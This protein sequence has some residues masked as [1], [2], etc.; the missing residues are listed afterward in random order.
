MKTVLIH[1]CI[2]CLSLF[3][4]LGIPFL[5][6][7]A[8]HNLIHGKADATSSASVVLKQP[9]GQYI[10]LINKA[11]HTN[12]ENLDTWTRFFDGKEIDY[13]FEDIVCYVCQGDGLGLSM[14]QSYQSR[15]P[16][17]QMRIKI[18]DPT[19]LFSKADHGIFDIVVMSKEMA[20]AFHAET[21]S[22]QDGV[23][24]ITVKGEAS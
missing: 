24:T 2:V 13:L 6:T 12:A 11:R 4:I 22:Q 15:L 19:L 10:V 20:D 16:A 18:V 3:L 23:I 14:A 9:S 7:D 1:T 21:I 17:N 5:F 8:F